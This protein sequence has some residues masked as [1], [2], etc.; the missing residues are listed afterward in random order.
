M[1]CL[2]L[3]SV[4]KCAIFVLNRVSFGG[5]QLPTYIQTFLIAICYH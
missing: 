2:V 4:P 5:L 3:N 1:S